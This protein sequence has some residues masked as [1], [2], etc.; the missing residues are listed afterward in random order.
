MSKK[1]L[2]PQTCM[3]CQNTYE[4][5]RSTFW[6]Q[7]VGET[8]EHTHIA[9]QSGAKAGDIIEGSEFVFDICPTCFIHQI[10]PWFASQGIQP[11]I[12]ALDPWDFGFV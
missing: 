1:I 5:M 7:G 10:I 2:E 9:Y 3:L 8:R 4:G 6:G 12:R 11:R